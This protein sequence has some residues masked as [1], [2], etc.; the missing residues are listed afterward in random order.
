MEM[1]RGD[2]PPVPALVHQPVLV[3]GALGGAAWEQDE[4]EQNTSFPSLQSQECLG[5]ATG[6]QVLL[7]L[8]ARHGWIRDA[9]ETL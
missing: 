8:S 7:L 9:L 6:A 5:R 3:S 4:M 1:S 2:V